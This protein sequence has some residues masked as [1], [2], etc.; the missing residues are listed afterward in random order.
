MSAPSESLRSGTDRR[1]IQTK[2]GRPS[3]RA[4]RFIVWALALTSTVGCSRSPAPTHT[5]EV[6]GQVILLPARV[7][8]LTNAEYERAIEDV[9]GATEPVAER[10]PPDV[11]QDGYTPNAEQAVPS[12][13]GTGVEA[14]ARDVA[15][16]T[17]E[18]QQRL[19]RIAPC[20]K[21]PT[22]GCPAEIVDT[23][24]RR[25]WRRPLE[26]AERS[27]LLG[28][29]AEGARSGGL[30]GGAEA[31]LTVLLQSPSLVYLTELGGGGTPGTIVT[32]TPYEI[33]SLLAF[34]MRGG[35]PDEPLL[36][37]AATGALLQPGVREA[38]A[39]RLL[40]LSSTRDH[41]RRFVLEWLE[42]DGLTRTAKSDDLFPGYE[43]VKEHMLD[44]TTAFADE[45]MVY[46][47]GSVRALLDARFASVDPEMARFYGLKTW[48]A[49]AS[50]AGTRRAGVLQQASFL[51]AHAHEDTTSPVK[52]GDFV[53][54]RLLCTRIPRPAEVGI[55]TVFP[56]P[57]HA[58]TTRERFSSHSDNPA[59]RGCHRKLDPL[60]D[61]FEAFDAIGASRAT[62]NGKP[63]DSSARIELQSATVSLGD[64]LDLSERLA[65]DPQVADCYLRQAFRY[66]TAQADPRIEA[67]LLALSRESPDE[68]RDS[69]FEGL[70]AY[71][72]SDLFVKREVRP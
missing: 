54:R 70:L 29:F 12:A 5:P 37:A 28:V 46:G 6:R 15:H 3:R 24:G 1:V 68:R 39:R 10:L 43:D 62:D 40:G 53:L 19:D 42:V 16:R 51:A 9:V 27:M 49:R 61:T 52:R 45:V 2:H 65:R 57:S 72:R 14:I 48:G 64:S 34:T 50:L 60:G 18:H 25:A 22:P 63:I 8:R 47:G 30:P 66:F 33:A 31:V 17:I 23:L 13:W 20:A 38:H 41:F 35:P 56:P 71:V 67:E 11:R 26:S 36:G 44:E 58:K 69:L 32:L 59:C 55:E 7:R 4:R 21:A